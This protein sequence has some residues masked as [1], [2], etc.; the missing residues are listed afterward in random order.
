[1]PLTIVP[2]TSD[3][4]PEAGALFAARHRRLRTS[5]PEL[6]AVYEDAA[7]AQSAVEAAWQRERADGIA[8]LDAGGRL[9]AYLIGDLV[10]DNLWGRSGW[11]RYAGCAVAPDEDVEIVRDLYAALAARW[12]EWGCFLHCALMPATDDALLGRWFALCFGIEHVHGTVALDTL[13]LSSQPDPPGVE[14]RRA[15]PEDRPVLE[16]LSDVIWRH[17]VQAPV[18]GIHL[19][20]WQAEQRREWGDLVAEA[21]VAIWLAFC[22]GKPAGVQMYFPAEME[23]KTPHIPERC[24]HLGASGTRDWARGRGI[25]R[26]LTQHVLAHARAAGYTVCETDWRST[27]LLSSR[28]WPRRGFRPVV[29]RLVRR[30]D[31]RIAW[32]GAGKG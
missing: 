3:M 14:I 31:P 13:D 25:G 30:V 4:F 5:Q 19:P 1:M 10:L 8:A 23:P 7:T 28:F 17:Q 26:A 32:A 15:G 2:F 12:V 18:W 6:P 24:V 27:N 21:D 16:E 29:Y 20:E 22:E 9:R 11:V